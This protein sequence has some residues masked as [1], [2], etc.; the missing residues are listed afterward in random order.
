[1]ENEIVL[2]ANLVNTYKRKKAISD[3]LDNLHV[4][5]KL[6]NIL[7]FEEITCL[8]EIDLEL[9]KFVVGII[10][11]DAYYDNMEEILVKE[12]KR[13][14]IMYEKDLKILL[15]TI[16]ATALFKHAF[17]KPFTLLESLILQRI[18]PD[19][20][21]HRLWKIIMTSVENVLKRLQTKLCRRCGDDNVTITCEFCK[22]AKYC[23]KK[24]KTHDM[25]DV[26]MGHFNLECKFIKK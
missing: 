25:D 12:E 16:L 2:L 22:V 20:Y 10:K 6:I 14:A 13:Y 26:V 18:I 17:N 1:M 23:N 9:T 8:T 11:N 19:T 5:K 15:M 7:N 4:A 24:C 3:K 21:E